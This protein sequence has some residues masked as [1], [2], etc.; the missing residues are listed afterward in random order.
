[1]LQK[2]RR[3][4][5]DFLGFAVPL[6][7]PIETVHSEAHHGYVRKLVSYVGADGDRIPAY[8][9]VPDGEGPFPAVLVHHQHNGEYHLRQ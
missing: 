5:V 6:A 3:E 9:L 8:L 2:L 4:V 1:M 7:G